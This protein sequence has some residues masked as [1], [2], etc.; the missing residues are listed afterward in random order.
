MAEMAFKIAE[1]AV[2]VA[3]IPQGLPLAEMDKQGHH[4]LLLMAQA[5]F[6]QAVAALVAQAVV[7]LAE[8]AAAARGAHQT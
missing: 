6:L 7:T 2:A 3:Q 5:V 1:V 8:P 4:L